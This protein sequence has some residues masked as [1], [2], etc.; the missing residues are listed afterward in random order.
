[1]ID[2]REKFLDLVTGD[3]FEHDG[4]LVL[5]DASWE[6]FA[7]RLK[8]RVDIGNDVPAQF[9][10]VRVRHSYRE[11]LASEWTETVYLGTTHPALIPYTQAESD[12]YF[13]GNGLSAR[14]LLG[15]VSIACTSELGEWHGPADFLNDNLGLASG[16]C[17]AHGLLGRFP[18]P[19]VSRI[20]KD[21]VGAP[22]TPVV[23]NERAPAFWDGAAWVKYSEAAEALVFGSCFVVG[24]GIRV[25]AA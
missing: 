2:D 8:L 15:I 25:E 20:V 14:E 1:M 6:E 11:R 10:T 4:G 7:L 13:T 22:I 16:R 23:L 12:I 9:W 3:G 18:N 17:G 19:V 5:E 24:E 21:L